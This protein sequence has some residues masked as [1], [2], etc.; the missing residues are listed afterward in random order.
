MINRIMRQHNPVINCQYLTLMRI[1][2]STNF[3]EVSKL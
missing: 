1:N 3:Q 2:F